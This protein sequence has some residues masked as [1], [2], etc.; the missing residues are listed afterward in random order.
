[1]IAQTRWWHAA[2]ADT[3]FTVHVGFLGTHV[4]ALCDCMHCLYTSMLVNGSC[5][6]A[7]VWQLSSYISQGDVMNCVEEVVMIAI[8]GTINTCQGPVMADAAQLCM[9]MAFAVLLLWGRYRTLPFD[10]LQTMASINR[11]SVP[12]QA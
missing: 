4:V 1:M 8:L 12:Y 2:L 7:M 11:L 9:V 3:V 6:E 5:S 10:N